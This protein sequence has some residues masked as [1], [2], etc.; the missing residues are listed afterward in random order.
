M[1]EGDQR[2]FLYVQEYRFVNIVPSF[3]PVHYK[4]P[5]ATGA[6]IKIIECIGKTF[7][8]PPVAEV[9]GIGSGFEDEGDAGVDVTDRNYFK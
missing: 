3:R 2:W 8:S 4:A 7:R 1:V 5:V 9:E 6:K